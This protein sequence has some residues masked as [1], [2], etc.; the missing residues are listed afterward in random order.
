M[1]F[2]CHDGGGSDVDVEARYADPTVPANDAGTPGTEPSAYYRHDAVTAGTPPNVHSLT[3]SNEFEGVLNRHSECADCHNAHN[4]TS[5]PAEQWSDGWS[6][7][8][9]QASTSGVDVTHDAAGTT[10]AYKFLGGTAG[11]QPTR[12]YEI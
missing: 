11:A 7:S 6:V 12:A 2:T 5:T 1:C 3:T 10:P 9:G 4:A 8:G